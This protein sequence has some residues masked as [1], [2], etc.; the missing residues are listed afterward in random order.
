[1]RSIATILALA[2]VPAAA[3][4][5]TAYR[6]TGAPVP[7][8][9]ECAAV[10]RVGETTR[11]QALALFGPPSDLRATRD[12]EA[13]RYLHVRQQENG[14]DVGFSAFFGLL[15][16]SLFRSEASRRETENLTLFFDEEGRL[17]AWSYTPARIR[18]GS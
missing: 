7:F 18:S 3:G 12:G 13:L 6:R 11:A 10:L 5:R 1:M 17:E 8:G 14:V 9:P 2:L 16:L 15:S 4:C